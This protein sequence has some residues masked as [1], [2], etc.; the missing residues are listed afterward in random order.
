MWVG[1]RMANSSQEVT[2]KQ[3]RKKWYVDVWHNDFC[4]QLSSL[5]LYVDDD[6]GALLTLVLMYGSHRL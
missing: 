6:A 4:F 2:R 5:L 1:R 3:R